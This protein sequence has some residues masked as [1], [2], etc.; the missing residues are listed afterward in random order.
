M[1]MIEKILKIKNN[2]NNN[3][4]KIIYF[5]NPYSYLVI[6]KNN[7]LLDGATDIHFDGV[8]MVKA[9]EILKIYKEERK[10]FDNSSLAPEVFNDAT[11]RG[12]KVA[13]IGSTEEVIILFNNYLKKTY[14]NLDVGYVRNG[15]FENNIERESVLK[16]LKDL[17]INLVVVGMGA[18]TQE[19][20][21]NDLVN[22]GWKG[23][24][25]TCGGFMHQTAKK[26][27]NYYPEIINKYNMRFVY[28]IYD[29]PKLLKRYLIDY[30]K[31]IIAFAI[32]F[33]NYKLKNSK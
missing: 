2:A 23:D 28:R 7:A 1:N 32:D 24:A 11:N 16:K 29:E 14:P 4:F 25:Y 26:G 5:L 21:I 10:S 15:Y 17:N 13:L 9:M 31:F 22:S 19:S 33:I 6:R 27:H 12:L 3:K 8:M 30:P 18:L 20:F